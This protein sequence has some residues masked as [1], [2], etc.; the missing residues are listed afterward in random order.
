[1]EENFDL[2]KE[3]HKTLTWVFAHIVIDEYNIF[4]RNPDVREQSTPKINFDLR[5]F[6]RASMDDVVVTDTAG[7]MF[8]F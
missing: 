8:L 2:T 3:K 1:M 5:P 7:A 6:W 4:L